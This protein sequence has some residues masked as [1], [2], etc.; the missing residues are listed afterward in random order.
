MRRRARGTGLLEPNMRACVTLAL[1]CFFAVGASGCGLMEFCIKGPAGV[2]ICAAMKQN[3]PFEE[4]K[5]IRDE[6]RELE[7]EIARLNATTTSR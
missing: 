2:Q 1:V 4:A 5:L 7:A 6:M 3:G